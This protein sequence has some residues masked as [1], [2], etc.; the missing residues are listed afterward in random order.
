MHG[1]H[2]CPL[3][4]RSVLC[5]AASCQLLHC[6][7]GSR[8][9]CGWRNRPMTSRYPFSAMPRHWHQGHPG[10]KHHKSTC[11]LRSAKGCLRCLLVL[12][13]SRRPGSTLSTACCY[14]S[15]REGHRGVGM[16][17]RQTAGRVGMACSYTGHKIHPLRGCWCDTLRTWRCCGCRSHNSTHT[18]GATWEGLA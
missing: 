4:C 7:Q 11:W 9:W 6:L 13:H 5:H 3:L 8:C 14:A 1:I 16:C 17:R 2:R 15:R 18:R 10:A 12:Q